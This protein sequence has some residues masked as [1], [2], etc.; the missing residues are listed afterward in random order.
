MASFEEQLAELEKVVDQLERGGQPLEESVTLF[1]R[2]VTL[3]RDCKQQLATAEGRIRVLLEPEGRNPE[4]T[5]EL[6][7]AGDDGDEEDEEVAGAEHT[8]YDDGRL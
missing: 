8:D 3:S 1:E 4:R 7:M 5:E 6:A 2:G